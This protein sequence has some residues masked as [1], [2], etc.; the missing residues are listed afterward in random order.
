VSQHFHHIGEIWTTDAL[1]DHIVEVHH[2]AAGR[3]PT[4][5]NESLAHCHDD[6]HLYLGYAF[7]PPH[8]YD[9]PPVEVCDNCS[10]HMCGICAED[11]CACSHGTTWPA[12]NPWHALWAFGPGTVGYCAALCEASESE[13]ASLRV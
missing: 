5:T 7:D 8:S 10:I 4:Y 12:R 9:N 2:L 11:D 3:A 1:R 6:D 13:L